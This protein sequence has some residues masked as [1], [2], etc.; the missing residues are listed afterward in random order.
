MIVEP[1]EAKLHYTNYHQFMWPLFDLYILYNL[2]KVEYTI[3]DGA[4]T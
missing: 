3:T 4:G 2:Y 1:H